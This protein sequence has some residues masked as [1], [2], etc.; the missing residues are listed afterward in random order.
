MYI[1][2]MIIINT[3]IIIIILEYLWQIVSLN[4]MKGNCHFYLCRLLFIQT[5]IYKIFIHL[6]F[7]NKYDSNT[8][9]IITNI[10]I[11]EYVDF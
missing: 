9:L 3:D 2:Q 10:F 11:N 6:L 4:L 5:Y 8:Q 1:R 7:N